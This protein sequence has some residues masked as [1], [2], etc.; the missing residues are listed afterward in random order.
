M[1]SMNYARVVA[2]R[3]AIIE[4]LQLPNG[5]K[6]LSQYA[7]GAHS[8]K[9]IFRWCYHVAFLDQD[10]L[11]ASTDDYSTMEIVLTENGWNTDK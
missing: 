6:L 8:Q 9:L 2:I 5:Q 10:F 11:T 1:F 4:Y 7:I 3:N